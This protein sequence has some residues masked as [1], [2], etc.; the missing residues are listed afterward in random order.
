MELQKLSQQYTVRKLVREDLDIL[1][2]LY[3]GNE[4]FYRYHPPF[5]TRDSIL[6]DM[7]ALPPGKES[8]D[9]FYIGFFAGTELAA[10]MDLI[11][12][13]PQEKT[14]FIGFFMMHTAFQGRSAGS[15][16]IRD[17]AARLACLGY[18]KLRLAIDKG[19]PQSEAF[20]TKNGFVKTGE[21]FPNGISAYLP[22]ERML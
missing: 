11:L 19:N 18:Q 1:F 21:E 6:E 9:K 13:Y 14:G 10:V 3:R 4:I 22:M 17:C 20:W 12:D 7:E 2:D 16:I 15:G 5:V 8:Q